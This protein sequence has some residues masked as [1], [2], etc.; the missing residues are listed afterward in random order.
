MTSPSPYLLRPIRDLRQ[1]EREIEE[2]RAVFRRQ[3]SP[4]RLRAVLRRQRQIMRAERFIKDT[5]AFVVS[6]ELAIVIA[7]LAVPLV[8]LL[9]EIGSAVDVFAAAVSEHRSILCASMQSPPPPCQ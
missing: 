1:A 3:G 2:L 8:L 9:N 5:S 6:V 7:V 4:N